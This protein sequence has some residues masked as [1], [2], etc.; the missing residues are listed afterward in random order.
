M[1]ILAKHRAEQQVD[2]LALGAAWRGADLVFTT[3][4]GTPLEPRNVSREWNHLRRQ[5]GLPELRLHD[6]RHSCATILVAL[7]IHPRVVMEMLRHS[8]IGITMNTYSHVAPPLQRE[9]ADALEAT[10]SVEPTAWL[11]Y[12][13]QTWLG[14][15]DETTVI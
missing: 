8:E 1:A 3:T 14:T 12:W 11:H 9:A 4:S 15:L 5:A 10:S 6:L 2:R 13:L 7:G